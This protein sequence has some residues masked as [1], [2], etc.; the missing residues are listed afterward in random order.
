MQQFAYSHRFVTY[1]TGTGDRTPNDLAGYRK[2]NEKTPEHD[3]FYIL[4][5]VFVTEICKDF[6]KAKVCEV[7]SLVN[8][9]QK[10]VTADKTRYQHQLKGKGRLFLMLGAL[11][12]DELQE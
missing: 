3:S 6:D 9:L 12:P 11:P 8:W 4:P 2:L 1:P 10:C 7:L 5:S